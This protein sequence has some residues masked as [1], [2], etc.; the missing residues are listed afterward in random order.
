MKR[1]KGLLAVLIAFFGLFALASCGKG[2]I[3]SSKDVDIEATATKDRIDLDITLSQNQYVKN[4]TA[5]FYVVC[6][7][8]TDEEIKYHSKKDIKFENSVYTHASL[9]FTSLASNQEYEF[10][11]DKDGERYHG[12]IDLMLEYEDSIDVIDYKLKNVMDDGYLQ[13]LHGYRDYVSGISSKE[14]HMYLYS[15]LDEKIIEID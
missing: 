3:I 11:Y 1:F 13:Q 12:V 5:T 14:I 7:T 10:V 2:A 4:K 15:L 6:K 8:V 9:S